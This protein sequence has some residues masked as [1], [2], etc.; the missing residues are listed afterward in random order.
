MRRGSGSTRGVL[1]V[2][3]PIALLTLAPLL[4][5]A[6]LALAPAAATWQ[7]LLQFVLRQVLL[8]T[9]QLLLLVGAGVLLL[10][11][12]LAWLTAVCEFPGR[13]FF[14]WALV[15]PLAYPAYVLA[16]VNVGLFEF[17]GPVQSAWR[18]ALGADAPFPEIRGSLWGLVLVMSI[19]FYPYVYLMARNAFLT[20]GRLGLEA[21]QALGLNRWQAF[22]RVSLPMAR[23]WIF[24]GLAL[25]WMET[26]ADFGAV[27]VFNRDT[28]TTAVYKAWFDLH[29]LAAAAQ[30]AAL[31]VLAVLALL[32]LEQ[33]SRRAQRFHVATSAGQRL[34]L[35]GM[36]RGAALLACTAVLAAGFVVPTLQL[37]AWAREAWAAEFDARFAG[38]VWNSLQ[39]ALLAAAL[40][41]VLALLLAWARRRDG[42]AAT[43]WLVRGATIGY[44]VPG[45]VLAVGVFVPVA[46]LDERLLTWLQ[47]MG[48]DGLQ[49]LKGSLA[50]MLLALAARFLAVAYQATDSAM[51][52]ITPRQEEACAALGLGPWQ[53]LRRLH[54][55]LL[56]T[57]LLTAALLVVVDVMKEMPITLMMRSFGWDT[58]AVRVFQLTSE[59]MWA[60]AALPALAIVVVGLLPVA[61][62]VRHGEPSTQENTGA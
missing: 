48:Y 32:V 50:A 41:T 37:L 39:L 15:L 5:V 57:G 49:L 8:Q 17:A 1:P 43:A 24:A 31:L 56:R 33:A 59:S 21:A 45:V 36:A 61:L 28:F 27:A 51:Q 30:L 12:P 7:H 55:P 35:H 9:V 19:A 26:L 42:A 46:W 11:V 52:R 44:A 34:R 16:F 14:A 29:D 54:L 60:E 22:V 62:L 25:A 40:T 10:G 58:L 20:Q 13:R 6:L 18:E 2:V 4:A 53:T 47:P 38:F 3:L 23:P